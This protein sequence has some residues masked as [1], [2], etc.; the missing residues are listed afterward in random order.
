MTASCQRSSACERRPDAGDEHDRARDLARR[1]SMRWRA[2]A[3][4]RLPS[5]MNLAMPL[6]VLLMGAVPLFAQVPPESQRARAR[7]ENAVREMGGDTRMKKM[8]GQQQSDLVEFVAGNMLFVGFHEMG[9]AL[10]NQL[11]LPVL[12][13]E[14]DAVD[15][16][17]TLAMLQEGTE[18]SV[19]VLVQAARGWFLLDRRDRKQGNMLTFYDDHGLDKQRAYAVVCLMVGSDA[20]QFKELAD[21][22]QMPEGRQQTCRNDYTGAKESWDLVLK[23]F[24]RSPDQPKSNVDIAYEPGSGDLDTYARSFRSIRFLET[25]AEHASGRYVLPRPIGMVMRGCGDANA[26]WNAPTL[27]ETL[28]YEMAE[29]FVELYRGYREKVAPQKKMQSNELIAQNVK[30]IRLA[31]N[32]SMSNLATDTGLPEAWVNRMEHGLENC[33]VDQLEKLARA[34]KVETATFFVQPSDKKVATVETKS[35]S[36]K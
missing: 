34:L 9:H 24:L 29:D 25:L 22:V 16:F 23:S 28:C 1:Q 8:S 32:M 2:S 17:A 26:Y 33:T 3:S 35:R 31:H 10:V 4:A 21:W 19:N 15:A 30:R 13:R 12:G 20:K 14:E 11:H 18:F 36:R 27:K 7:M 6:L 5:I